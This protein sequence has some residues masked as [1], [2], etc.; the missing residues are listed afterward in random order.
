MLNVAELVNSRKLACET[1]GRYLLILE[2][3]YIV[4]HVRPFSRNIRSELS[5]TP[6]V[7]FYD[8]GLMQMLWLKRLQKE[9]LGSVFETSVFTEIVKRHGPDKVHYWR[10][11]D[12][13]EIDFVLSLPDAY[14]PVEA[15]LQFNRVLPVG[16]QAF[17]A[18]GDG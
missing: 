6:K 4:R 18:Y 16:L 10:T 14:L 15:K 13:K 17:A 1:V 7:F 8:T 11:P 3:T 12:K 5:K 9:L 2:Q